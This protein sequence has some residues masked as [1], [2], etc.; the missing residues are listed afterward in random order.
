MIQEAEK[1][2][3]KAE[4]PGQRSKGWVL[5][6]GFRDV[7]CEHVLIPLTGPK[8][9]LKIKEREIQKEA[10]THSRHFRLPLGT[11]YSTGLSSCYQDRSG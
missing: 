9:Y 11:N 5:E 10:E 6:R 4:C 2:G 1:E 8:T 3:R 7:K